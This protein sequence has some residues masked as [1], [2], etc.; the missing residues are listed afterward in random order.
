[1]KFKPKKKLGQN[2][3]IDK[4]IINLIVK[5]GEIKNDDT[6]LEIGPGTGNLTKQI[7]AKNPKKLIAVEKDNSLAINLQNQ[8][9]NKI[10]ILNEDILN[11]IDGD[12]SKK[13]MIIFGNLPYN[14]SSQI[15]VKFIKHKNLNSIAKKIILMFQ[16]EVAD[17]IVANTNDKQYGRLSILSSWRMNIKKIKEISPNSFYPSPKVKSTILTLEPKKNYFRINNP[18]NLEHVTNIFFNQKRKMIKKPLSILFK[19]ANEISKKL[20]LNTS[21]RPQNLSPLI[22]FKLCK[23]YE[24]LIN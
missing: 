4:N 20:K 10:V 6:I 11:I 12:F 23:E 14:I 21:Q 19:N 9:N 8:F 2:F 17:R 24:N 22:Y 5:L 7:L 16:K 13:E 1:V 3:L 15:L 18:K